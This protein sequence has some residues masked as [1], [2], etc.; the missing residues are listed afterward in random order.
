MVHRGSFIL[1]ILPALL[2]A[3]CGGKIPATPDAPVDDGYRIDIRASLH[4]D[5]G[6]PDAYFKWN[7]E[8]SVRMFGTAQASFLTG[9]SENQ[10]VSGDGRTLSFETV[11][12]GT[13]S[14][15]FSLY[16]V[17]P[18]SSVKGTPTSATQV[19]IGIS[20]K[21]TADIASGVHSSDILLSGEQEFSSCPAELEL[22]MTRCSALGKIILKGCDNPVSVDFMAVKSG[23]PVQLAGTTTFDI[24]SALP[25]G[26]YCDVYAENRI[27]INCANPAKAGTAQTIFFTCWPFELLAGDSYI[28]KVKDASGSEETKEVTIEGGRLTF[29]QNSVT[30][31]TV[32]FTPPDLT[33]DNPLISVAA[34]TK[35]GNASYTIDQTDH[36][37]YLRHIAEA[38]MLKEISFT[39]A[40]TYSAT[41]SGDWPTKS[42]TC[43]SPQGKTASYQVI[44]TDFVGEG[45]YFRTYNGSFDSGWQIMWSDEFKT[46][47]YDHEAWYQC[48]AGP[49]YWNDHMDPSNPALVTMHP[50]QDAKHVG[51]VALWATTGTNNTAQNVYQNYTYPRYDGYVTGGIQGGIN[52]QG[53][54]FYHPTLPPEGATA[55]R[56]DIRMSS[57]KAKGFWPAIWMTSPDSISPYLVA[58]EMDLAEVLTNKNKVYQ[59]CH[60]I[61]SNTNSKTFSHNMQIGYTEGEDNWIM[62]SVVVDDSSLKYYMNGAL[63]MIYENDKE[64][65][66]HYPYNQ[67]Y[68]YQVILSAQL[69]NEDWMWFGDTKPDGTDL[70]VCMKVDFVRIYYK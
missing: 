25:V 60:N 65:N 8:E 17:Y 62:Y 14:G 44:L 48:Q 61:Y 67:G 35:D 13:Y 1:A 6:S 63:K 28:V 56:V 53:K 32:D 31:L 55:Y 52:R 26:R 11:F 68:H 7:E 59:T 41:L 9:V 24:S 4:Q 20:A 66:M 50:E 36:K 16:G 34:V 37:V 46:S 10:T 47:D 45:D 40:E 39:C 30:S 42:L 18:S 21:Q 70:P 49:S 2:F 58:G 64:G 5:S 19:R 54:H 69:G 23:T 22:P 12:K 51:H 57:Q 38:S 15:S 27:T 29:S 3:S 33:V 43:S